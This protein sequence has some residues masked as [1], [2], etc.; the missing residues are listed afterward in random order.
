MR[1]L[2][3]F[4]AFVVLVALAVAAA[5][6]W[7]PA[8]SRP[9]SAAPS[10]GSALETLDAEITALV[11]R[12]LPSVVSISA[13]R[14]TAG[15]ER[16]RTIRQMFGLPEPSPQLGSGVVV[17]RD[18]HIVTNLH[19]VAGAN[20]VDINLSDGRAMPAVLLGADQQADIAILKIAVSDVEPL[21]FADSQQVR[22]GQ[23]VFA[24]G[25]PLGLQESVTQGIISGIGRRAIAGLSTEFFQTDTAINPGNSGSPLV[26]VRGRIVGINNLVVPQGQGISFAIPANL[27]RRVFEDVV[28]RGEIS[29]PWFG[30]FAIPLSAQRAAASGLPARDCNVVVAVVEGS[31]AQRAGIQQGDVLLEMNGRA[32]RDAADIRNRL[33]ELK[34]GDTVRVKVLRNGKTLDVPVRLEQQPR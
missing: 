4:L 18:G 17:S 12:V 15:V 13:R 8:D 31:P 29:R 34:A 16:L 21:A 19:V 2:L 11:A 9:K 20:K 26:D 14:E 23:M 32:L 1:S 28:Q 6:R 22:A 33:A 30:A 10:A 27:A 25:N 5:V 7:F 3:Q 24:I